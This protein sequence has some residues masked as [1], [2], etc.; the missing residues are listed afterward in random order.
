MLWHKDRVLEEVLELE[1][2]MVISKI[3]V[4]DGNHRFGFI[5]DDYGKD[6]YFNLAPTDNFYEGNRV[7]FEI[8]NQSDGRTRAVDV[9]LKTFGFGIIKSKKN[10]KSKK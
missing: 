7:S 8:I 10:K 9:K 6:H 1:D 5:T 3:I 4:K 2:I